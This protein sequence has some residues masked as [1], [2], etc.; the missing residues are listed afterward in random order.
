MN[1]EIRKPAPSLAPY[2]RY[3]WA[4]DV[5]NPDVIHPYRVIPQ[6]CVELMFFYREPYYAINSAENRLSLLPYSIISGQQHSWF[7]LQAAGSIGLFSVLFKPHGAHA[8]LRLPLSALT[9][10]SI[11]FEDL[12]GREALELENKVVSANSI[13]ERVKCIESFLL[14]RIPEKT[15]DL[16][17]M[18]AVQETI[19]ALRAETSVED[20]A[21][22]ACLGY[23][24]LS[25]IFTRFIGM[26]PKQYLKIVRFQHSLHVKQHAP[27]ISLTR[28]AMNCGYYDQAHF[29]R[30]FK[31]I[32]GMTPRRFF[33]LSDAY[34]DF[35]TR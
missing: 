10:R 5:S 18:D 6:G 34:S 8:F 31:E 16:R 21:S 22:R 26:T 19:R 3:Y 7:E 28:L 13:D 17:R 20:L 32:T 35:F 15:D 29:I 9:D 14:K 27:H 30:D 24:Q 25:R 11:P 2:V 23:K 4:L 33:A 1:Y 12:A